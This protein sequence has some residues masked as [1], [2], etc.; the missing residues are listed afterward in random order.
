M[1]IVTGDT[2]VVGKGA[3]D[4]VY[5]STAGV[6]MI[7]EGRQLGRDL[8][9][10]GDKVVLSGTIGEHGMAVM[11]ARGD[12]A[13]DADIASDTAPVTNWSRYLLEGR[14]VDAVDA[15]RDARRRR[16]GGQRAGQ[17]LAVRVH[18][19]RGEPCRSSRKSSARAT[20]SASTRFTWRTRASSSRSCRPTRPT[21]RRRA[22]RTSARRRCCGRR[23]DR[24]RTAR[25][26]R[27][28]NVV[29][30]QPDRRHARRRPAAAHLLRS[31]GRKEKADV[32][33]NTR[34]G[35]RHRRRRAVPGQGRRQRRAAKHQRPAARPTTTCRSATGCS[36]TS[37]SRWPRST[38]A[39]P[40]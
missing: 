19:R 8:V 26:R 34:S 11:L 24:A 9:R 7:P 28:S 18:P 4:G 38:S 17:G 13:I 5:I 16:H 15:R 6:G 33:G 37:V 2:K 29:R 20:C 23:R 32:S 35:G 21:R 36:C 40:P 3:A 14:A 27:A 30:R 22:A 25:H 39:R 12:L 31:F 1:Q 10:P